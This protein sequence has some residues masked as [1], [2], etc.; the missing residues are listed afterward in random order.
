MPSE[1]FALD[2]AD[3]IA[4][5]GTVEPERLR[6]VFRVSN[7]EIAGMLGRPEDTI[8][9]RARAMAPGTR[10]RLREV[11]EILTRVKPWSGTRFYAYARYRSQEILAFG[12]T[13]EQ[14]VR[15][16]HADAVKRYIERITLGDH[17]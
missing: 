6:E 10:R 13:A 9:K 4:P 14:M 17:A 5:D 15:L 7:K 12:T 2:A 16:G 11:V 8:S 3:L 1:A